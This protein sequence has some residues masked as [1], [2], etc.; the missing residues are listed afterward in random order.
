MNPENTQ[1]RAA[2]RRMTD[3]EQRAH[4]TEEHAVNPANIDDLPHLHRTLW[5]GSPRPHVAHQ[6]KSME[7]A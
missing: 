1:D 3:E 6:H 2:F 7:E 4:L 5:H